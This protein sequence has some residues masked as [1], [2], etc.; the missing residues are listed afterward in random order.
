M[1][2][3]FKPFAYRG[4]ETGNRETVAHAIKQN[5]APNAFVKINIFFLKIVFVFESALLPDNQK[6]GQHLVKH[7]IF[8]FKQSS[9]SFMN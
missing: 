7:V 3:G 1:N 5:K 9:I 6:M 8:L 2:F 4:L